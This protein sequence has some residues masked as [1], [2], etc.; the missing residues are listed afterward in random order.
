MAIQLI[1]SSSSH[2][3]TH[4]VLITDCRWLVKRLGV[5]ALNHVPREMNNCAHQIAKISLTQEDNFCIYQGIPHWLSPTFNADMYG[6]FY[7]RSMSI[8]TLYPFCNY[9]DD[10]PPTGRTSLYNGALAQNAL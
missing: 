2:N 10:G 8:G 9:F 7:T 4:S 1:Q 5:L 6:I 3:H